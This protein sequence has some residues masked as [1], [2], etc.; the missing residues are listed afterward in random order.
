MSRRVGLE[1]TGDRIRAV[2]VSRWRASPLESFEIKWDPRAPDD[3]VDVL[4]KHLGAVSGIGLSVGVEFL[5]LKNVRLPPVSTT[6]KRSILMLEPDRFFV[7]EGGDVVVS[8]REGSDLV[9]AADATIVQSW[10]AAFE[11]WAPVENVEAAPASLARAMSSAGV[12]DGSFRLG[13]ATEEYGILELKGGALLSA[14]RVS[15]EHAG[16]DPKPP[17]AVRGVESL[18]VPAFGAVLGAGES[19]D[20]MLISDA[21]HA[22]IRRRRV[23]SVTRAAINFALAL[24]FAIAAVDRSRSRLLE[25][26]EQEIATVA[27]LAAG[28]ASLQTR[29]A[30][31]DVEVAASQNVIAARANPVAVLAAISRRLPAGATVMSVRADGANWQ[32]EGTARDAGALIPALSADRNFDDVRFLSASSRYRDGNRTYETFS[33]ALRAVP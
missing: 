29:L 28:G 26:L 5:H 27:P 32:M 2:T 25:S 4:R 6:E 21:V 13:T 18:F 30:A 33:I 1:L 12:R 10:I 22:R 24:G 9:F 20:E 16:D 23:A 14:R 7:I 8:V 19:P 3:A 17:A 31:M 15:G 11:R